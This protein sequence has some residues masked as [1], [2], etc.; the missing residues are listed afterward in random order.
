MTSA[1]STPTVQPRSPR[2]A[3]VPVTR[4][5]PIAS[6]MPGFL[7][8]YPVASYFPIAF[9][10][11]WGGLL[12]VYG[13]GGLT[14][15]TW[16]SDP[17]A[18]LIGMV[19]LAGPSVAGV[20]MTG[21]VSG[22]AGYRELLARMVRWRV[23]VGWYAV[24]LVTAPLLAAATNFALSLVA[25]VFLP[26]I[27]T[28]DDKGSLLLS[29][30]LLGLIIGFFEE[31]GWTGFAIPRLRLR[32]GVLSTGLI[33]GVVWGA[34]HFL[35]NVESGSFMAPLPL[36]L[37][38]VRVFSWLPA[39][40][41]LMVGVYERTGSLLIAILM[42]ASLVAGSSVIFAPAAVTAEADFLAGVLAW[43]AVMWTVVAVV[44]V[45]DGR[46]AKTVLRA[47]TV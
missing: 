6:T 32:Y 18:A 29:G 44:A 7:K 37:L 3:V 43:A 15:S 38:L 16:R 8:K 24:A 30:I 45:A 40:R 31:L 20:L 25:P 11:S 12:I 13:P 26:A 41:L 39:F 10:I 5:T 23:G 34:W 14:S 19:L 4:P 36:A 2:H 21:V 47:Q 42:H 46:L 27:A 22:R 1:R 28:A 33:V 17:R 35:P 9:A